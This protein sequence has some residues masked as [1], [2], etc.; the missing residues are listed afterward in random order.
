M[1]TQYDIR[2]D[3]FGKTGIGNSSLGFISQ[4]IFKIKS[5]IYMYIVQRRL[6]AFYMLFLLTLSFSALA[7]PSFSVFEDV[8]GS[9]W[10]PQPWGAK[11]TTSEIAVFKGMNSA[12]VEFSKSMGVL[13][14][15][16]S[17]GF[18]T[19][20]YK[21]II[22]AVN[23]NSNADD[24]WFV[25]QHKNGTLGTYLKVADYAD[26]WNLPQGKWSWVR[27]PIENLGL[28]VD[29]ILSFF[30]VAS[31][32]ANAIAYFDD[33]GFAASSVLYEGEKDL[34]YAPGIQL[35]HWNGIVSNSM[36]NSISMT[37]TSN[38]GGNAISA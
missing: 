30:S 3:S 9:G 7:G 20:G 14:Y 26:K 18:S 33:I 32:K 22:F 37:T 21:H 11:V 5:E 2:F 36:S 31:G 23:N 12:K 10:S 25:A 34:S 19:K 28:G 16:A 15:V 8:K 4:D 13:K 27:I 1:D 38:W 29:P 17:G 6:Y 35:W 24:L